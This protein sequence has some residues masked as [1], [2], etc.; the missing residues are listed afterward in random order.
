MPVVGREGRRDA[1][2][3]KRMGDAPMGAPV[4]CDSSGSARRRGCN[5]QPYVQLK[6]IA[7]GR[8]QDCSTD[9]PAGQQEPVSLSR[10]LL[11]VV[12]VRHVHWP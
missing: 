10:A 9:D 2:Q 6:G 12:H 3:V 11:L 7:G 1:Q 8:M 4:G 5:E